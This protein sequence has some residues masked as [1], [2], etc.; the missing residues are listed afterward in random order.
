MP[1]GGDGYYYFSVYLLVQA[2]EWGRFHIEIDGEKLCSTEQF[3]STDNYG[4]A[5]CSGAA[6][7]I[8]GMYPY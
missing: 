3:H 1:S 6:Y 8:E 4:Q 2:D 5:A 7:I